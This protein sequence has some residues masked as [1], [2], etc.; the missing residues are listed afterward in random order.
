MRLRNMG[1][2]RNGGN[3]GTPASSALDIFVLSVA[4]TRNCVAAM[5]AK[6][7]S[8]SFSSSGENALRNNET[9]RTRANLR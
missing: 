6:N 4:V 7:C 3:G 9:I 5:W 2:R 8:R 1:D